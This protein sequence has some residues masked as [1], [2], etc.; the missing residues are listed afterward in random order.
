VASFN[1]WTMAII[2]ALSAASALFDTSGLPITVG[3]AF[4]A[5]NEFR[6]RKRLLQFDPSAATMLGWNQL[7]LLAMVIVYCLWTLYGS[8]GQSGAVAAELKSYA[9][10]DAALGAA[11]GFEDLYKN[12]VL[13]IYGSVIALS[14]LF[15][16]GNAFYYFTRRR[17]I[18]DYIAETPAWIREV[19]SGS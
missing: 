4:V 11:G 12:V 14:I 8:F 3:L 10:L 6:G 9:D 5:F 18:E 2:A 19:Q 1:G 7:G 13:A 17:L 16:G 15:Q